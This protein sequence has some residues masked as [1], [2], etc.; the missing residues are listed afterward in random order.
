VAKRSEQRDAVDAILEQWRQRRPDLDASA[1]GIVGRL[2]RAGRLLDSAVASN[3]AGVDLEPWEFDVLATLRRSG[4]LTAGQLTRAS[5]VTSGAMTNRVDHLVKRGLVERRQD[6][7]SRR[8]VLIDLTADGRTVVDRALTGHLD[9][10]DSLAGHLSQADRRQL[11][12]LLRRL[13]I[14]LG[15][16]S[17]TDT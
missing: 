2:Q 14:G 13:L 8:T 15:D 17:P 1:M 6:P 9:N 16:T 10:L 4:E 5:M 3:L 7:A 12:T 11:A